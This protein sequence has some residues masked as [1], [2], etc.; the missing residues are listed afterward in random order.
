MPYQCISRINTLIA[1]ASVANCA[2]L[3]QFEAYLQDQISLTAT[4]SEKALESETLLIFAALDR[5][6]AARKKK[7]QALAQASRTLALEAIDAV[8]DIAV[9]TCVMSRNP[10]CIG[11]AYGVKV[12]V[13]SVNFGIQLYDAKS[14]T[15]RA[16]VALAFTENRIGLFTDF[17][18]A[19]K[20]KTPAES[21][22][23]ALEAAARVAKTLSEAGSDFAAAK[24]DLEAAVSEL[25][26]LHQ[27]YDEALVSNASYRKYRAEVLQARRFLIHVLRVAYQG[28][29][30][31]RID[32][33][34]PPLP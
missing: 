32:T 8:V 29:P 33:T 19:S 23:R 18:D 1:N 2:E 21:A 28:Q 22:K 6:E 10:V 4:M 34:P 17:L 11:S 12:V 3:A 31:C 20:P 24:N 26:T 30:G 27:R 16:Q 13:G 5:R 9:E 7:E 25:D 14:D 15:E